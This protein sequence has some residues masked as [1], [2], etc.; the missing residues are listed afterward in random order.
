MIREKAGQ[1]VKMKSGKRGI[2]FSFYVDPEQIQVLEEIRWRE[3]E[4]MSGLVRKALQDYIKAH[5]EGNDCFKLDNWQID[6][7]FQAVPTILSNPQRWFSYLKTCNK[8]DLLRILKQANIIRQHAI[9]LDKQVR[10]TK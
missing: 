10:L 3:H 6:P 7:T 2:N 1:P 9:S 4:S 5:A 8:Q